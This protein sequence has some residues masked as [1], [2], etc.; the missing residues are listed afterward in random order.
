MLT[1]PYTYATGRVEHALIQMI[2]VAPAY[3]TDTEFGTRALAWRAR[4]DDGEYE[5]EA[6][7]PQT[8]AEAVAR[9]RGPGTYKVE[10][11][12]VGKEDLLKSC[13]YPLASIL[14]IE[15]GVV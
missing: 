13:A 9:L 5:Y 4:A 7:D 10:L 3:V 8:A 1:E 14:R 6:A 11:W 2:S 15:G 12:G